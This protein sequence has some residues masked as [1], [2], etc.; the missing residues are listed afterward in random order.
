[1]V[2]AELGGKIRQSLNKLMSSSQ[3]D[4]QG[5]DALL[6]SIARALIEADVNVNV[7]VQLRTNVKDRVGSAIDKLALSHLLS[8]S[9]PSSSISCFERI[10]F[11]D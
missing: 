11:L 6:L 8:N 9:T 7:V 3:L 5:H 4:A 10:S 1:M 2:L